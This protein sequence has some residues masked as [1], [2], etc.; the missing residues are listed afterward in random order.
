MKKLTSVAVILLL[1]NTASADLRSPVYDS[2]LIESELVVVARIEPGNFKQSDNRTDAKLIVAETLKGVAP[3]KIFDVR[4]N[5][6]VVV[7]G[8]YK[9]AGKMINLRVGD[10]TYPKTKIVLFEGRD[11]GSARAMPDLSKNAIWFLRKSKD[12]TRYVINRADYAQSLKF[13]PYF[14]ALLSAKPG[15]GIVKL[16]KHKDHEVR[17]RVLNYLMELH[18]RQDVTHIWPLLGDSNSRIQHQAAR[19]AAEVGDISAVPLF[20]KALAH[21]NPDVREIAC[22]F[23]CRFRD[24]ESIPAIS[25]ALGDMPSHGRGRVAMN[26]GRMESRKVVP[27]LLNMLDE[28]I[29]SGPPS[30]SAYYVSIEAAKSLLELTGVHFPYDTRGARRIWENL[31]S[32]PDEVLIR[33]RILTDIENLTHNDHKVHWAAYC[34]LGRLVNRHFGSYNA[35]H[36]SEEKSARE[37]SQRLWRRWAKENLTKSRLDWIYDGFKASGIDLPRP[38]DKKGVD[39]LVEVPPYFRT[40]GR[41]GV[42]GPSP[43]WKYHGRTQAN[44]H[45]YNANLLLEHYTGHKVGLSPYHHD[46]TWRQRDVLENRWAIWWRQNRDKIKLKSWLAAKPVSEK[47]ILKVPP[48]QAPSKPLR[49]TIRMSKKSYSKDEP[50][51]VHVQLKNISSRDIT[52]AG[53]PY[54]IGYR[55][56]SRKGSGSRGRGNRVQSGRKKEDFVTLKPGRTLEWEEKAA[57]SRL[58]RPCS[59]ENFYYKL[60][61]PFAGSQF[62]LRAWRGELMSNEVNYTLTN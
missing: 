51:I 61:Y 2:E 55:Y 29:I 20:R 8:Y 50:V 44:F 6:L 24:V 45:I 57:F 62:G 32:F 5:L 3:G 13:K 30:Q 41:Q 15:A 25:K 35:F 27:L 1:S 16:L 42:P 14:A 18:R 17:F 7:G 21:K 37:E 39:T 33:K 56:T 40:W 47:M 60:F 59:V 34:R 12:E 19:A 46:L 11:W 28:H 43:K 10:K 22:S 38:M 48:L 9:S 58:T 54:D 52:I 31:K 26:L 49:V 23:L 4:I 36:G 53:R